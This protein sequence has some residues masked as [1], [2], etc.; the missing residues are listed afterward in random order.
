VLNRTLKT[1]AADKAFI[2]FANPQFSKVAAAAPTG[3]A[4]SVLTRSTLG[5][6]DYSQVPPL[7]ETQDE[8]MAAAK[9]AGADP[10]K[11]VIS[12]AAATRSRVLSEKLDDRRLVAFATHGVLPGE[13]P[14]VTKPA[15]AMA[16]EGAGTADSLLTTDDIISLRLGADW[17]VLSACNTGMVE[18]GAGDTLSGMAR[19]FFAAGA[20]SILATQWAVDSE[21]AKQLVVNTL[22]VYSGDA[23][24]GRTQALAQAQRDMANG[25]QGVLYRHPYFWAA[26]FV[27]GEPLR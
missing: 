18:A 21:S 5:A 24:M 11:D 2:A 15:L 17:V 9:S 19:A 4:R 14:G 23:K 7:P 25:K 6:F 20:K 3:T 10:V 16:Y 1:K 12:G 27:M 8:A 22:A 13:I 26:Y